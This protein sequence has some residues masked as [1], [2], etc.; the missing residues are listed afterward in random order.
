MSQS[1]RTLFGP[2]TS[3]LLSGLLVGQ[4]MTVTAGQQDDRHEPG[5]TTYA[6]FNKGGQLL[7]PRNYREWIFIGAPVT[8]KDM[9]DGNPA[10]PEFHNVYIDPVSW[11]HWKQTGK[12]RDGTIIVKELV[13]VGAEEAASGNGYFQGEYLGI[14]ATVKDSKRFA[15][16]PN[17][18]AY[19]GYDSY[20]SKSAAPQP[21][22]SCNACHKENAAEDNVFTQYYPVLRAGKPE[23]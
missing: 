13:S 1:K 8:P 2:L 17:N 15:D 16:R 6:H 20:K 22:E 21:D 7:T 14:V 11:A 9:N 18:W 19:F 5:R 10:F 3:F 23:K 4:G 12:F